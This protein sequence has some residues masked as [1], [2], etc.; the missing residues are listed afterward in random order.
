[1]SHEPNALPNH[2]R[3][4]DA[5]DH[6]APV[7]GDDPEIQ[8]LLAQERL[9]VQLTD[10]M[11]QVRQLAGLTQADLAA[12]MGISQGRVS[13]LE[14]VDSDRRLDSVVAHLHAVGAELLVALE[15]EDTIIQVARPDGYHVALEPEP[16]LVDFEAAADDYGAM[17]EV[18]V[19][20]EANDGN[21]FDAPGDA[22]AF[23]A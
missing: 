13:R 11:R 14:S 8:L 23:A 5:V 10:G 9:R 20:G 19:R 15:F 12:R 22:Y 21:V 16:L 18:E 2:E 4:G 1:M 3:I 17:A 7:I 6:L